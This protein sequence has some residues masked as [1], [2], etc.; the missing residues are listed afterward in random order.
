MQLGQVLPGAAAGAF[1]ASIRGLGD[2]ALDED[3]DCG[4]DG[5]KGMK[6]VD[7][8]GAEVLANG[9][10]ELEEGAGAGAGVGLLVKGGGAGALE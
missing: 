6:V 2:G 10:K 5:M 7:S 3:F 9:V 8:L 1:G 4:A